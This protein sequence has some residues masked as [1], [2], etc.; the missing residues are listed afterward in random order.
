M[1]VFGYV[2]PKRWRQQ[3]AKGKIAEI[4]LEAKKKKEEKEQGEREGLK[5]AYMPVAGGFGGI[6]PGMSAG[7][8]PWTYW[9]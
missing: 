1:V 3:G 2:K 5:G 6:G 9:R 7:G 8:T 4:E